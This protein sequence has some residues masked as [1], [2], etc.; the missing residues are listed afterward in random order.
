M[1]HLL[2]RI[3]S[4]VLIL[5][6]LMSCGITAL[7]AKNNYVINA[8]NA[9]LS[10]LPTG[11]IVKLELCDSNSGETRSEKCIW[12]SSDPSVA[13]VDSKGNLTA[14]IPGK[15]DISCLSI[16]GMTTL[17]QISVNVVRGVSNLTLSDKNI[18]MFVGMPDDRMSVALLKCTVAPEDAYNKKVKWTSSDPSVVTVAKNGSIHAVGTGSAIV[19]AESEDS[20][21]RAKVE[22]SVNVLQ[23]VT[24]IKLSSQSET[25]Y[26]GSTIELSSE[27]FPE[28]AGKNEVKWESSNTAV[29]TVDSKGKVTAKSVGNVSI[30]CAATDGSEVVSS[31]RIDVIAKVTGL[32]ISPKDSTLLVGAGLEKSQIVL[33]PVTVPEN[34]FFQ[35][36]QWSSSDESVATVDGNGNVQAIGI[37][38]AIITAVSDD[39]DYNK[40]AKCN[41]N[42]I[43]AVTDIT[44]SSATETLYTGTSIKLGMELAPEDA[45]VK[46]VKWI[47]SEPSVASVDGNGN[48]SAKSVGETVIRCEATDG[49]EIFGECRLTVVAKVKGLSISDKTLSLLLGAGL[50][51]ISH[52]LSVETIPADALYKDIIWSSS[53]DEVAMVDEDGTVHAVGEGTAEISALSID[54]N[55]T[56]PAKCKVTV[57]QAV[58]VLK[59]NQN[60]GSVYLNEKIQ[61]SAAIAPDNAANKKLVWTSS[62]PEVASV[63]SS[64]KVTGKSVGETVITCETTD[65]SGKST[66]CKIDVRAKVKGLELSEKKI[67]L[68]TG[69][70]KFRSENQLKCTVTPENAFYQGLVW[71]SSDE[72]VATVDKN[73]FVKGLSAGTAVITAQSEDPAYPSEVKCEVTVGPAVNSIKINNVGGEMRKGETIK[74][75]VT[76]NPKEPLNPKLEWSSN[77]E[78]VVTVDQQGNIRAVSGGKA[79]VTCSSTDGS[80][81]KESKEITVV[82]KVSS[83]NLSR[84]TFVL[85]PGQTAKIDATVYPEDATNKKLKWSSDSK[86][87]SVDDNGNISGDAKWSATIK[88][89]ATDG[90]GVTSNAYVI[91]EPGN[92]VESVGFSN[93]G[94]F[95]S[96]SFKNNCITK[97][98]TGVYF[99]LDVKYGFLDHDYFDCYVDT[100]LSPGSTDSIIR[101]LSGANNAKSFSVEITE[102]VFSDGTTYT[103]PFLK[104]ETKTWH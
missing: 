64:G 14:K 45:T 99:D 47:S 78:K 58:M 6:L 96:V 103:V 88:C 3:L 20:F 44:L 42:V 46:K 27:V 11:A 101:T 32:S 35:T 18:T 15:A 50:E 87:V 93:L 83:I 80:M 69:S 70:A 49:S 68:L 23:A 34:A 102:L 63:D 13:Y 67:T 85:F 5:T 28:N 76:V 104:R 30:S 77:N 22:C 86:F 9:D 92:P 33:E 79:R 61:L 10:H 8:E 89:E 24:G 38:K 100:F 31:C 37:G 43:N 91:I 12:I 66:S 54:P 97:T 90:S 95:V 57:Q 2:K 4:T 41:V 25:I 55:C 39:P 56:V 84:N 7:A 65:G 71:K 98:V 1:K 52:K 60:N 21:S 29:A 48:V 73:G 94:D 82:Q 19:T 51:K 40:P 81:V 75:D 59:L 36:A 53:D 17:A 72:K 16:D 62:N 74:A 26:T